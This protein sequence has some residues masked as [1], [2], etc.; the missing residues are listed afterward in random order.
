TLVEGGLRMVSG[1]TDNHLMMVDVRPKKLTGKAA[2]AALEEAGITTNKN[3]IPGDPEKP[4][5]TSGLRIGTPAMTTR[6]MGPEEMKTVGSLILQ[7]LDAPEDEALKQRVR[8]EVRAL[9][10]R[11]PLYAHRLK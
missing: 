7:V 4:M 3:M 9:C 5:V 1:G 10:R 8:E 11:F 2:E 6:G